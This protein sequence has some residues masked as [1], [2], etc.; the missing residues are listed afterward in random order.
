[1]RAVHYCRTCDFRLPYCVRLERRFCQEQCRVWWYGHPGRKRLDFAPSGWGLPAHPGKGRPKTL[2]AA[3][4]ELA[5]ARQHAAELEAAA[6]AMQ[7]ADHHLRAKLDEL[8]IE[9]IQS[10]RELMKELESLQDELD[11][12]RAQL[13]RLGEEQPETTM[14]REQV[15]SL[16]DR[17]AESEDEAKELRSALAEKEKELSAVRSLQEQTSKQHSEENQRFQSQVATL[18]TLRDHLNRQHAE[19]S[20]QRREAVEQ[21]APTK[22]EAAELKAALAEANAELAAVQERYERD[23]ATHG[24][25]F[26]V[27][28]AEAAAITGRRDD[29]DRHNGEL[30]RRCDEANAHAAKAQAETATVRT[31]L[32]R[33]T[34]DL[35]TQR[36]RAESAEHLAEQRDKDLRE[37]H[38]DL[39][40]VQRAHRD[41]HVVAASE[42]RS[43]R[44]ERERRVAAEQRVE[45]LLLELETLARERRLEDNEQAL[46][47]SLDRQLALLLAENREVRSHRDEIDAEREHLAARLLDWMSPGQYREHAAAADYKPERDLLVQLKREEILVEHRYFLWQKARGKPLQ[48]RELDPEQ[49][50][51]EQAY[52]A[53]MS[54][55][56]RLI[57]RMHRRLKN[58][59]R[60]SL[61]WIVIGFEI[62]PEGELH[63]HR[64]VRA[65]I[66]RIERNMRTGS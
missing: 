34:S 7:L 38:R 33:A 18:T 48:A 26:Q 64:L 22:T 27:L 41:T 15:A 45:Q 1:M 23:A 56:W 21:L 36:Q 42:S 11:E 58:K 32:E 31:S 49:T 3:L 60:K 20:R 59:S 19:M 16:T 28:Q 54:A 43:L 2:A 57:H 10:R 14:L 39:E 35:A 13:A 12:A 24:E 50:L 4:R 37:R 53:A 5:T 29:L 40:A 44:A 47:S 46:P 51:M 62:Q 52:A 30:A 63:L 65:N 8:R 61:K 9:A 55:R 17:L 66:A 6:K 25:Q